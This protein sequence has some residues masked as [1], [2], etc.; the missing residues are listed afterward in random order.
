M[1]RSAGNM[2]EISEGAGIG[3]FSLVLGFGQGL[4]RGIVGG[5]STFTAALAEAV[6]KRL[7]LGAEVQEIGT[8]SPPSSCAT[9]RVGRTE[10]WKLA[11][12]CS[13]PLRTSPTG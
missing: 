13:P 10:R 11:R 2:D 6:D 5:P 12:W 9:A 3:Y 8:G 4:T 1:T 7:V